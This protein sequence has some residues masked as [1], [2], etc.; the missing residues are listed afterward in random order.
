MRWNC[1]G[2]RD[3]INDEME[4]KRCFCASQTIFVLLLLLFGLNC[5]CLVQPHHE[6]DD[7]C[8]YAFVLISF[9]HMINILQAYFHLQLMVLCVRRR[10]VCNVNNKHAGVES[11]IEAFAKTRNCVLQH[12]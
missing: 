11:K 12:K 6:P 5:G 10:I 7:V 4:L 2:R 1:A 8:A 3:H 9:S